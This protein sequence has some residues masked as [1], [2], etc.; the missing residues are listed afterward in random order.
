MGDSLSEKLSIK[1][2]SEP[3]ICKIT[4]NLL[5]ALAYS[6]SRDVVHKNINPDNILF[7]SKSTN[8]IVKLNNFGLDSE[9]EKQ[10]SNIGTLQ[11]LAPEVFKESYDDP[12][13]DMWSV[14]VL[15]YLMIIGKLPF[16]SRNEEELSKKIAIGLL[17]P[18]DIIQL[19]TLEVKDFIKKLLVFDSTKRMTAIE[20]LGHQWFSKFKEG[21]EPILLNEQEIK[22]IRDFYRRPKLEKAIFSFVTSQA[23][24]IDEEK[25]YMKL[26]KFF[27]TDKNGSISKQEL[28]DG[29]KKIGFSNNKKIEKILNSIKI[30]EDCLIDFSEFLASIS[31]WKSERNIK[32]IEN[33]FLLC[34]ENGKGYLSI[35]NIKVRIPGI[36]DAEWDRFF[37]KFDENKDNIISI[38]EFKQCFLNR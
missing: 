10:R 30:D 33:V 13:S 37:E 12:A 28:I 9:M 19:Y 24:S 38:D 16:I 3:L 23:S 18:E 36:P 8:A 27:D 1:Y 5:E 7:D 34:E 15:V 6:H 26:F 35:K 20:A 31:D 32:K 21:D 29:I 11:Y 2:L 22:F 17:M 4:K 25:E 14:G